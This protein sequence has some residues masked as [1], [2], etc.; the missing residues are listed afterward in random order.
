M[1]EKFSIVIHGGCDT[2]NFDNPLEV[3]N[4]QEQ[5]EQL[6]RII[7]AAWARVIEGGDA[8]DVVEFAINELEMTPCFNAGIG[9]AIDSEGLVCLDASIMRGDSLDAGAVAK[10]HGFPRA[11]SV[12]RKVMERTG[13]VMLA[14]EGAN[15][16]AAQFPEFE[17]TSNEAFIT[18]LQAWRWKHDT[19]SLFR[20]APVS[21]AEKGTVGA[22]VRDKNGL[23]VAGTSTGGLRGNRFGRV[24]DS[25][26]IGAGCYADN[27]LGGA[28]T[29]GYGEQMIRK[30]TCKSALDRMKYLGL[31]VDSAAQAAIDDLAQLEL[32]LGWI[33]LM[34]P[35]GDIGWAGKE[36][37]CARA[38]MSSDMRE[39]EIAMDA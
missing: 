38:R 7:K 22:V 24:G 26:I 34:N 3:R 28:S 39:P 16:F 10:L 13:Q 18:E 27:S 8:L 1:G 15:R 23:I 4:H 6:S 33:I 12:A 2:F 9:G 29:T 32:G 14:G 17:R 21:A 5:R 36:P 20:D 30:S 19:N 31:S 11:V 25:P 35:E 37:F